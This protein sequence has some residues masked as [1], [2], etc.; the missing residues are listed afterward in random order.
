M[1]S[2]TIIIIIRKM[3]NKSESDAILCTCEWL[4]GRKQ[5]KG[6]KRRQK[7]NRIAKKWK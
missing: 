6:N 3:K 7:K 5:A 4:E 2:T 1:E